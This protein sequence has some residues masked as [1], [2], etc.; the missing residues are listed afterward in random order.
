[1]SSLNGKKV[2]TLRL[3][4]T[5]QAKG[6]GAIN[7]LLSSS[8]QIGAKKLEMTICDIGI[9]CKGRGPQGAYEF[10]IPI[11]NV[12]SMDLVAEKETAKETKK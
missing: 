5:S 6:F 10:I 12:V 11:H 4:Q 2:E 3:H 7:S 9:Y 8:D 1:M